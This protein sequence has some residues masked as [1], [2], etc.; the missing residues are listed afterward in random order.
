MT[1]AEQLA[2]AERIFDAIRH[3]MINDETL[4]VMDVIRELD[5]GMA[6]DSVLERALN[7]P[8]RVACPRCRRMNPRG[9]VCTCVTGN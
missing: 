3:R 6:D 5:R 2:R 7:P 4:Q 9:E 8:V 1:R